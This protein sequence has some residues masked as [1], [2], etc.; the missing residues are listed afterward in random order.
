M[1]KDIQT[2]IQQLPYKI[3]LL[4][5]EA[6]TD[7]SLLTKDL[8]DVFSSASL[9]KVPILLAVLDYV[10][11]ENISLYQI[12]KISKEN[13]VEFSV[14]TELEAE[15]CA[16][17]DLLLWMIIISDNT[18]TNVLIDLIGLEKLNQ[19]FKKIGLTQTRIQRKMMDFAQLEK[20]FDNLT[21]ARDM[22]TLY[23]AI[24]RKSLL[25]LEYSNLVIDILSRQRVYD[26]LKRYIVDDVKI[27][28]K[29]GSLD[30]VEHDVGIVFSN[31]GDYIIGVFVTDHSNSEAAKGCIGK[32]SMIVYEHM[33]KGE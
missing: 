5:K 4:V 23:T 28:H 11:N 14:L 17:G 33:G 24:Y 30:T 20:G 7:H 26:S 21:T 8:D 1:E 27:A 22:G 15:E 19:Y 9:I 25:S 13:R 29:T 10:E 3:K 32:I 31:K 18:A 16:L 2:L 6:G 12:V